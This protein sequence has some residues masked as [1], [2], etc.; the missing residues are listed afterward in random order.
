[1]RLWNSRT[2]RGFTLIELLVVIAIIAIL[3]ALLLPA[4]Q[5]AREAAR[6]SQCRNHLKQI[7]LALHNYHDTHGRF[8]PPGIHNITP[9][10]STS[11]TSWGPSWIVLILPYIDQAP[12]YAQY[13]FVNT[14]RSREN[15]NVVRVDIPSIKCPSDGGEK[16]RQSNVAE[17]ARGN[18]G[19]NAGA[20]NSFRTDD[21]D[22]FKKER[23]P[24]NFARCYG[25]RIQDIEDGTSN[26]VLVAEL[27]A[28]ERTGDIRGAWA[29]PTGVYISGGARSS[30]SPRLF[31]TP[32]ANALDD[33]FRDRPMHCS[34]ENDDRHLR[35]LTGDG[36]NP[37]FYQT[38]R[39]KHSGGVQ[40]S[41]ADGSSRFVSENIDIN[42]WRRLLSQADGEPIGDF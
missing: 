17:F 23:G 42:T 10:G 5:Q 31:L 9:H 12:L 19:V 41:L 22:N 3:I 36:T 13:D 24:F 29:Y 25:A 11:S 4:V 28:G 7:G 34:A 14:V 2:R 39:S 18:Y 38:S 8:P 35:C 30:V 21:F 27:I 26:T 37:G 16:M 1:M 20:W 40:L 33:N 6:R 32:N 15:P